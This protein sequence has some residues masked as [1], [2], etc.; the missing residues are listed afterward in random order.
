[1]TVTY[2]WSVNCSA[3]FYSCTFGSTQL[4]ECNEVRPSVRMPRKRETRVSAL[5]RDEARVRSP[6]KRLRTA[7]AVPT[8]QETAEARVTAETTA[9]THESTAENQR[10]CCNINSS[11]R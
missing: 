5:Y 11:H 9:P 4:D 10:N 2:V 3:P 1:M 8:T 6:H 7:A